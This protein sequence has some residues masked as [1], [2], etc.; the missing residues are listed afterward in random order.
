MLI[1]GLI[2]QTAEMTLNIPSN[3][4]FIA[5]IKWLKTVEHFTLLV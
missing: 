1:S 5:V 3:V 4:K 2:E